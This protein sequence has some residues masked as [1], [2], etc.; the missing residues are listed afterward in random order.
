MKKIPASVIYI[1]LIVVIVLVVGFLIRKSDRTEDRIRLKNGRVINLNTSPVINSHDGTFTINGKTVTLKNGVSEI[2]TAPDSSSKI[3]TRYFGNDVKY[4]FDKDGRED[5][6]FIITQETGGTGVFYYV[7]AL[8]NKI[9]GSVGSEGLL[10]GDH[11]DPQ[12][13]EIGNGGI[14]I[15]NYADRKP[16]ESFSV[17]PSVA[18]S[19]RLL[20]DL[21][22]I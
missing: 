9:D 15:V 7:V 17:Q 13:T 22:T 1:V 18:K 6:A 20:L 16:N 19:K 21:S 8:L 3:I 12:T 5:S 10:L 2:E 4:D 11:I 14:V